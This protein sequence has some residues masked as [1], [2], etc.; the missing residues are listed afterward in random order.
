MQVRSTGEA[1]VTRPVSTSRAEMTSRK[2]FSAGYPCV[3]LHDRGQ[4]IIS[5]AT[6][7][8]EA[9]DLSAAGLALPNAAQHG[10][11]GLAGLAGT[12]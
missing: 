7:A 11:T 2:L 8:P 10:E 12:A 4:L 3:A 6:D 1:G 9:V 5:A